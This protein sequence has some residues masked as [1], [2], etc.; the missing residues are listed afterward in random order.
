MQLRSNGKID[1]SLFPD[2]YFSHTHTHIHTYSRI[3]RYVFISEPLVFTFPLC[4]FYSR[5]FFLFFLY[6]NTFSP[7]F[8]VLVFLLI[9]LF[10]TYLLVCFE[11][12]TFRA[13]LPVANS[14]S[15]WLAERQA[16]CMGTHRVAYRPYVC[17]YSCVSAQMALLLFTWCWTFPGERVQIVEFTHKYIQTQACHWERESFV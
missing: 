6:E 17:M 3:P 1:D 7:T 2:T 12:I 13:L 11:R 9:N 14:N 16:N 4:I 8:Q 15:N 10:Y 5:F